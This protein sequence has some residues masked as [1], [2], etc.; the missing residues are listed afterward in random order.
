LSRNK[1]VSIDLLNY[2]NRCRKISRILPA[3]TRMNS[4]ENKHEFKS[5]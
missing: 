3:T 1:P 2:A 4:Q 5:K